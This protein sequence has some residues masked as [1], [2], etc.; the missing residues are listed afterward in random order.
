MIE[1]WSPIRMHGENEFM[2]STMGRVMSMLTNDIIEQHVDE[3]AGLLM[4]E[5]VTGPY[6]VHE[7]VADSHICCIQCD[8]WEVFHIDGDPFN[9]EVWNL[10]MR[11]DHDA[12][13]YWRNN[14][15]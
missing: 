3:E 9:N 2:V 11:L 8:I 1:V 6:W 13:E 7:L 15:E 10:D 4:V 14:C 12:V 5:L